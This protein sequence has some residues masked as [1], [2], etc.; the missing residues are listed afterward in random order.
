MLR[1]LHNACTLLVRDGRVKH[2]MDAVRAVC[3]SSAPIPTCWLARET[4]SG[5]A[6]EI[7]YGRGGR[8]NARCGATTRL[9][10]T[11]NQKE[12]C[13]SC[14]NDRRI[15]H[16]A[17]GEEMVFQ[18]PILE[19]HSSF[20]RADHPQS[21]QRNPPRV[22][23]DRTNGHTIICHRHGS[24]CTHGSDERDTRT[25]ATTGRGSSYVASRFIDLE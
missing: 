20:G 3:S 16:G 25:L 18:G 11:I 21:N 22:R 5:D 8:M 7:E 13:A 6:E 17:V 15:L 19:S 12:W 9:A 2:A 1:I 4:Q 23:G 14:Y 24:S 10:K